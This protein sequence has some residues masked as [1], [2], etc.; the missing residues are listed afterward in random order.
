METSI[1]NVIKNET[2]KRVKAEA[3]D[4]LSKYKK[5]EYRPLFLEAI[6]DSS[7]TVAGKAL[8]ALAAVDSLEAMKQA[9][10]LSAY[11]SEVN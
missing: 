11:P 6:N 2:N 8:E 10:I 1:S 7:Y 4:S 5:S 3:I 9:K